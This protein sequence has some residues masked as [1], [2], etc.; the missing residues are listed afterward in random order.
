MIDAY[1]KE[2][3]TRGVEERDMEL[4]I[5]LA[6]VVCIQYVLISQTFSPSS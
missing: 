1:K 2:K 6:M 4:L 5:D 3:S